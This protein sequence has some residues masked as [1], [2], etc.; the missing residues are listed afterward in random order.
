M[1]GGVQKWQPITA[2]PNSGN[3]ENDKKKKKF[4]KWIICVIFF[5]NRVKYII[6][7]YTGSKKKFTTSPNNQQDFI[8]N[9][10]MKLKHSLSHALFLFY[11]LSGRLVT[12]K[13]EDPPSYTIF[14]D[15]SNDNLK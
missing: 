3:G 2:K 12:H 7:F 15:W 5:S 10:L 9:L 6:F 11:P 14:I 1:A 4:S 13:T 8:E